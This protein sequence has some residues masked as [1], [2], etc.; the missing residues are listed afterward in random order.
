MAAMFLFAILFFGLMSDSGLFRPAVGLIVKTTKGNP[1]SIAVGTVLLASIVHLDGSGAS[2]FMIAVP[3]LLPLY[4]RLGMDRRVLA[5]CVAMAAGVGNMLPW[6]GPT[7]RAATALDIG[8]MELFM[9]LLPVYFAGFVS[10]IVFAWW[11][12]I[13]ESRRLAGAIGGGGTPETIASD[14]MTGSEFA[15]FDWRF[16]ANLT[17]VLLVIVALFTSALPPAGAFMLGLVAA[18]LIN[19]PGFTEQEEVLKRHAPAA[20]TMVAILFAAGVFTGIMRGSGMLEAVS[21]AGAA[22]LPEGAAGTIPVWLSLLA[23]PLSFLFDPDSFYFGILPVLANI[24]V[25]A[26]VPV[27]NIAHAALVGQMTTGFPVSPMTPATFLLI[28][29]ARIELAD[30]QRFS[31]LP[32]FTISIVMALVGMVL[33]VI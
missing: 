28:G 16:F 13:R 30:H 14:E 4:D 2:T 3:A 7:I 11:L 12:G 6:G 26:G 8:V 17:I 24:G 1:A 25:D 15:R 9:P 31:I 33:G 23:M 32:L 21:Q 19:T 27:E 5:A 20:V 18:V 10:A 29:L 22:I